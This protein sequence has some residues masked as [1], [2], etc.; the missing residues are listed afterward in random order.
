MNIPT[1]YQK[2]NYK[3]LGF[4][5]IGA[6]ASEMIA[7]AAI[8][9]EYEASAEDIARSMHAHPTLAEIMKEA[10]LDLDNRAIHH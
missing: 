8:A 7:E 2:H 10:A 1:D 3:I 9:F 6:H 5:I 4:H